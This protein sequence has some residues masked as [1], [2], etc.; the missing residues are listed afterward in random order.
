M[1]ERLLS[2]SQKKALRFLAQE[3][4]VSPVLE[5]S[6]E[7]LAGEFGLNKQ[8]A[9]EVLAVC[10]LV[11]DNASIKDGG[12]GGDPRFIKKLK[13]F[14]VNNPPGSRGLYEEEHGVGHWRGGHH[15]YP[16]L[17]GCGFRPG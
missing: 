8:E 16:G 17:Y 6:K 13:S 12:L 3:I 4:G 14:I 5:V 11:L 1:K 7:G 2:E 9:E 15:S 10:A